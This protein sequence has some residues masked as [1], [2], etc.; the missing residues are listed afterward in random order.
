MDMW[1]LQTTDQ[2]FNADQY[3]KLVVAYQNGAAVRFGDV[4]T[5][6]DRLR[7]AATPAC[8]MVNPRC[9]CRVS[10]QPTANLMDMVDRLYTL[11][12][13]LQASIPP[14]I[15]ITVVNDRTTTIRAGIHDVR[16]T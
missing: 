7:T 12:P 15:K 14:A 2:L 5:V 3:R 8:P 6:I 1:E 10:R 13:V 9:S 16:F 11:L 4:A